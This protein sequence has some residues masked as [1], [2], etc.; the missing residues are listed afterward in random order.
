[1]WGKKEEWPRIFTDGTR[2]RKKEKR[3]QKSEAV[4]SE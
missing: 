1:M 3:D 4:R 2:I